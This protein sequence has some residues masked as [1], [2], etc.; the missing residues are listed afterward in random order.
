MLLTEFKAGLNAYL[1]TTPPSVKT[2]T[3]A[4][5]IAFNKANAAREMALFGQD[6]FEQAE[7]TKGLDDPGL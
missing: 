5:V 6:L 7:K 1:A 3:L 2:R 4:D